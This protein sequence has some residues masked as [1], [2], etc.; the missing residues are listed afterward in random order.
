MHLK[1]HL[2]LLLFFYACKPSEPAP[3]IPD[4]KMARIMADMHVAEAATNGTAGYS[5]D[6]IT[7]VYFD[8]IMKMHGV[9][10]D[11]FEKNMKI[12]STDMDHLKRVLEKAR[13][14][15]TDTAK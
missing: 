1:T 11:S 4:D 6:S 12:L 14:M 15:V 2:L 13:D 5:K 7:H 3:T 8:Q 10:P 9:T